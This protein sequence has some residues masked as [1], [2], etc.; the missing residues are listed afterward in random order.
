MV[1]GFEQT[2]RALSTDRG[3]ERLVLAAVLGLLG[4][5][6]LWGGLGRITLYETSVAARVQA[7]GVARLRAPTSA[8]VQTVAVALGASVRSGDLLVQLDDHDAVAALA[9]A[10]AAVASLEGQQAVMLAAGE[11]SEAG[12]EAA[13]GAQAAARARARADLDEALA[14]EAEARSDLERFETLLSVGATSRAEVDAASRE[15]EARAARS[16]ALR[17]ALARAAGEQSQAGFEGTVTAQRDAQGVLA[18][19]AEL[20]AAR[21]AVAQHQQM[22]ADRA[23]RAPRDGTVGELA[24]VVPGQRL[25]AGE[26]VAVVVPDAS[27]IVEARFPPERAAGRLQPGQGARVRIVGAGGQGARR[28][29]VRQVGSEPGVD[30]L[31]TAVLALPVEAAQGLHHGLVAEVEVEVEA[32]APYALI[33]RAAGGG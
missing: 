16:R 8:E 3:L 1:P 25:S 26:L 33:A 18:L 10:E 17:A 22:L 29:V 7:E 31:V 11:A 15:L 21:A 2:T 24:S 23:I 19:S 13:E 27:L 30:G 14:R 9:A 28:A 32:V 5:W 20:A 6:L 4:V 12:R